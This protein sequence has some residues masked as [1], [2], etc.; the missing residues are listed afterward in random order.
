[1]IFQSKMNN[2]L[3]VVSKSQLLREMVPLPRDEKLF[4]NLGRKLANSTCL[5]SNDYL[6]AIN[7]KKSKR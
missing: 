1:M 2:S 3:V 4:N 5:T 6:F 7:L